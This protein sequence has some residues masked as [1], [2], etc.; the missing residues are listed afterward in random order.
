MDRRTFDD[1]IIARLV[2][3]LAAAPSGLE[4]IYRVL[5]SL[6]SGFKLEDAVMVLDDP[7]IGRQV[8]R[9]DRR[10][11][12]E[13]SWLGDPLSVEPG[14]HSL[15]GTVE[16]S[17][18]QSVAQLCQV[19]LQLDLRRHDASRDPLT[20]L[21]NRRSFEAVLE[22]SASQ[23]ARY[24]WPF[25]LALVDLDRLKALN[26]MLGHDEGDRVLRV[27][28]LHLRSSLRAG[29]TAARVGGDEFALIL[30]N[31]NAP[32]VSALIDR[33]KDAVGSVLGIEVGFSSGVA[34]SPDE[35]SDPT[36]LYRLADVRL[37]EDKRR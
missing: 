4:F 27:V 30:S 20:G 8:F 36:E 23:S 12:G 14:L 33:V 11:V 29:D 7:G 2:S 3:D 18:G 6:V 1:A 9:A 24:G 31:G 5:E 13:A 28:G 17:T 10:G 22:Q 37:Y 26:D 32:A 25:V 19:A 15:P 35:S 21:F 34:L 16:R